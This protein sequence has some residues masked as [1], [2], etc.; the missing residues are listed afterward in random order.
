MHIV[1]GRGVGCWLDDKILNWIEC[2]MNL[3]DCK[4]SSVTPVMFFYPH[5]SEHRVIWNYDK[6]AQYI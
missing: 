1:V 4:K 5:Y 2:I 6:C 3:L